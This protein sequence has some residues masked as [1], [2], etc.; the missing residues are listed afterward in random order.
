MYFEHYEFLTLLFIIIISNRMATFV[1]SVALH[2]WNMSCVL[3]FSFIFTRSRSGGSNCCYC[4]C[5]LL[6]QIKR[7]KFIFPKHPGAMRAKCA[8]CPCPCPCP[9]S[10][11]ALCFAHPAPRL[12]PAHAYVHPPPP[13]ATSPPRGSISLLGI[14]FESV[15]SLSPTL[16]LWVFPCQLHISFLWTGIAWMMNLLSLMAAATAARLLP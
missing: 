8:H 3:N 15:L 1:C 13:S 7:Y 11:P 12:S 14:Q 2:C 4:C 16:S 5:L 9:H 6:S 10:Y